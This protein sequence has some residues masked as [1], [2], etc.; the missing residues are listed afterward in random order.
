MLILKLVLVIIVVN[1][2]FIVL[3]QGVSFILGRFANTLTHSINVLVEACGDSGPKW[4]K[5]EVYARAP[6]VLRS[7][8][9]VAVA[10][11]YDDLVDQAAFCKR[12]DIQANPHIHALLGNV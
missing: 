1:G 6:G 12:S 4:I 11:D 2:G 8:N 3:V 10:R 7:G 9:K 5:N